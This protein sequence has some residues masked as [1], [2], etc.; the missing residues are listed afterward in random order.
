M[1]DASPIPKPDRS[2]AIDAVKGIGILQVVVHHALGQ[3][4]RNFATKGDKHWTAMRVV[5]WS[6][7]YAIPLF[8][9]LSAMLLAGSLLRRPDTGSFAWRR[10]SRTLWPYVIW[11]AIYWLL[12]R[13]KSPHAFD[14]PRRLLTEL[15]TGKAEYHLYFMV[16]LIQLT[17]AVPFVVLLLRNRKIGF[18][19]VLVLSAAL[20]LGA[21]FLNRIPEFN[22]RAPGSL[23]TWYVPCLLLG[24]WI[25]LNQAAW[26]A[27]WT[28]WRLI[29][30]GVGG[31][32]GTAFTML[33]VQNEL[34]IAP[35]S[36]TYN[37]LSVLFR[38]SLSLAI[39]GAATMIGES[40]AG[41]FLA[42][43]GR[44]S[45]PIYLA[46]PAFLRL[47]GG[48]RITKAFSILPAPA[49]WTIAVLLLVSYGF[50]WLTS[51]AR[52]DFVLFGQALPRTKRATAS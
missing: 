29:M 18:G 35:D 14:D 30:I 22:V 44:Y 42:A 16:I 28:R 38:V 17:I 7:N 41:S 51:L 23:N 47:L 25:A 19:P 39:L 33:S 31:L 43:L 11:S 1:A 13:W 3:G 15:L 32:A 8:L 52:L 6:T 34:G 40:S 12:R 4:A 10:L 45:L 9:L 37:G 48:P 24:V 36:L 26:T 2:L 49:F 20:Q 21:F 27:A 46:H 50:A 5:A